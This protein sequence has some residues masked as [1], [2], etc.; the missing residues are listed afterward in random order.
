[1]EIL[2]GAER[3]PQQSRVADVE[4]DERRRVHAAEDAIGQLEVIGMET[5]R[6][7]E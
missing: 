6:A 3:G 4:R 2:R 5:R 7:S 1:M